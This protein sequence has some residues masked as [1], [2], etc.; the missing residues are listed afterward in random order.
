[1]ALGEALDPKTPT[2]HLELKPKPLNTKLP[3]LITEPSASNPKP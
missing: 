1:V 3:I 2:P